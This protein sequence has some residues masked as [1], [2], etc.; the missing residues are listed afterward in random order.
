MSKTSPR[1]GGRLMLFLLLVIGSMASPVP[2]QPLA[3]H[4]REM[5]NQM[6]LSRSD[7]N[8]SAFD[9]EVQD[10][11]AKH[12]LLASSEVGD[13]AAYDFVFL[14]LSQPRSFQ[15]EVMKSLEKP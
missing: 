15:T 3:A 8:E 4:I 14:L 12:G 1:R 9:K 11:Y 2:D 6:L 10:I 7:A 5:T 13:Q